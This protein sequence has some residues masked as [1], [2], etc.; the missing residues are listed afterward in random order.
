MT[1]NMPVVDNRDG[2]AERVCSE[3]Q[4]SSDAETYVEFTESFGGPVSPSVWRAPFKLIGLPE[5]EGE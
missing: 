3:P 4:Q 2:T 1:R 5:E